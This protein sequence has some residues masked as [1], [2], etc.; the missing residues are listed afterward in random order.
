MRW[1]VTHFKLLL[2]TQWKENNPVDE[3]QTKFK[4]KEL[5]TK[6]NTQVKTMMVSYLMRR[7]STLQNI[8]SS[9]SSLH[10]ESV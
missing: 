1:S 8:N 10:S 7:S 3:Q 6:K 9:L 5:K 4:K 2:V